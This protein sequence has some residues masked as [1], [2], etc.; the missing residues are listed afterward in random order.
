MESNTIPLPV[1]SFYFLFFVGFYLLVISIVR[2][3]ISRAFTDK[4]SQI[5]KLHPNPLKTW[6]W[7][8]GSLGRVRI[9]NLLK[10][11]VYPYML[12]VSVLGRAICLPYNQYVF[13]H[14]EILFMNCLLIEKVPLQKGGAFTVFNGHENFTDLKIYLS[15]KKIQTILELAN[16]R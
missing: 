4:Y 13:K 1:I 7:C 9:K 16:Q 8:N 6:R 12:L 14:E 2:A 15:S 10:V 11:E 3:K 5:K